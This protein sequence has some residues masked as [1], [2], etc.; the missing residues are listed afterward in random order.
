MTDLFTE[1]YEERAGIMQ[2]SGIA[3]EAAERMATADTLAQ[4]HACEVRR[5][6]RR[7]REEGGEAVKA[8]LAE[9]A[10]KRGQAAADRLRNDALKAL[11]GE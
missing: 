4:L 10:K 11:K 9:V 6:V 7:Y 8:F 1:A 2:D 3:K 5:E